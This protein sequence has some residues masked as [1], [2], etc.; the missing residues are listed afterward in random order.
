MMVVFGWLVMAA[1]LWAWKDS[2]GGG[3]GPETGSV[4]VR[5]GSGRE[6]KDYLLNML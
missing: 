3:G 4:V 5:V 1:R 2:N 6:R